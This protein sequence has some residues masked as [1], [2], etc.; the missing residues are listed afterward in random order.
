MSLK[1]SAILI[2]LNYLARFEAKILLLPRE[3]ENG[4]EENAVQSKDTGRINL[5]MPGKKKRTNEHFWFAFSL[6]NLL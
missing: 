2:C 5:S 3:I 1:L 4:V 6:E